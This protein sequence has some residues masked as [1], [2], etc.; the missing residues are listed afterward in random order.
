MGWVGAGLGWGWL[1]TGLVVYV[2]RADLAG[3]GAGGW[4]LGWAGAGGWAGALFLALLSPYYG[5]IEPL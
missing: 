3:L 5:H 1:G 2:S 4:G